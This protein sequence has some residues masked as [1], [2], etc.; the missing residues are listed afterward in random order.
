MGG[1]SAAPLYSS[2]TAVA[3]SHQLNIAMSFGMPKCIIARI[4]VFY[5]KNS[6]LGFWNS[7]PYNAEE[8]DH[9][10]RPSLNTSPLPSLRLACAFSLALA[11]FSLSPI[12]TRN[13]AIA[14]IARVGGHFAVQGHSRSL[15]LIPT[16][17][18][19]TT[20]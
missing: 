17:S 11:P 18:P 4:S 12:Q 15:I 10:A 8:L 19:Y 9:G 6:L 7:D 2:P 14:E 16:E 13:S 3:S 5:L 1:G 20:S